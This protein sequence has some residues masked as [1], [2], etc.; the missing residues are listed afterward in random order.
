MSGPAGAD[1]ILR[2]E[3]RSF[4]AW[5]ALQV[6][7]LDGWLLRFAEGYSKRANSASAL[8]PSGEFKATLA[9][10]E[11][12]YRA[13]EIPCC[14]RLTPLAPANA[15]DLLES[16]GWRAMDETSVQVAD[17]SGRTSQARS[18]TQARVHLARTPDPAWI[19][20]YARASAR[21]DLKRDTLARMLAQIATPAAFATLADPRGDPVAFGMAVLDRGMV[22]LFDIAVQA[23]HRGQGFGRAVVGRLLKWGS[24]QGAEKAY[25]QVTTANAPARALYRTFGFHEAYRYNYRVPRDA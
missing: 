16:R 5:P 9:L 23:E 11:A 19:N 20:G 7:H 8:Q 24:I 18:E 2:L 14:F 10:I 22:G 1:E 13:R 6:A 21:A 15:G 3:E 12:Q 25:L 17:L 4:N